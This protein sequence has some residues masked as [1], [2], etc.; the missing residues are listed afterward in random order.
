MKQTG[1]HTQVIRSAWVASK[2]RRAR[3]AIWSG[4]VAMLAM[5]ILLTACGFKL[6]GT[7]QLPFERLSITISENTQFGADVRRAIRAVSPNTVIVPNEPLLKGE[8]PN[9]QAQL[10]QVSVSRDVREVSLNPQGRVE[11]YEL[12]LIFTFRLVN[13]RN[14]IILPDTTLVTVRDLPYDDNVV[15]AKEGEITT[16]FEQ[17]QR[18]MVERLVRRITSPDVAQ[19]YERLEREATQDK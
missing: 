1:Q 2:G 17:M 6:Q 7:T 12:T 19:N 9:Y 10:Q 5:T 4:W 3:P 14:E 15:Q 18:S 13:A 8:K 16:L 11:E